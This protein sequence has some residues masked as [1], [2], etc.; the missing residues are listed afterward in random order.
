MSVRSFTISNE[1]REPLSVV[2][3]GQPKV[4]I[5]PFATSAVFFANTTYKVFADLR[6]GEFPLFDVVFEG[7][8]LSIKP[9]SIR[10]GTSPAAARIDAKYVF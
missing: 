2:A 10:P 1:G 5:D 9:T 3:N 7:G 6:G 4:V 8:Q